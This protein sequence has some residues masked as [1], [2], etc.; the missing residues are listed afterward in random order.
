MAIYFRM[1]FLFKLSVFLNLTFFVLLVTQIW[2]GLTTTTTDKKI[3]FELN[4]N[5]TCVNSNRASFTRIEL[6]SGNYWVLYNFIRR[7]S[8]HDCHETITFT[9]HGDYTFLDNLA[10][11]LE[12]WN[13]PV[14]M[15]LYAPGDDFERTIQSIEYFRNCRPESD[16]IREFVSFHIYFDAAHM[17]PKMSSAADIFSHQQ[18]RLLDDV[19]VCNDLLLQNVSVWYLL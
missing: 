12:R 3:H 5:L 17:P 10:P 16:K 11:L 14:S 13:G 15:A 9:T 1:R 2:N 8:F 6:R 7:T 19:A 4:S 18:E